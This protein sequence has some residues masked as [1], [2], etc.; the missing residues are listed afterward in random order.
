MYFA[1]FFETVRWLCE[2]ETGE[3][4]KKTEEEKMLNNQQPEPHIRFWEESRS[5][6][7]LPYQMQLFLNVKYVS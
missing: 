7:P 5:N 2:V 4:Q 1:Y 6:Y 3:V